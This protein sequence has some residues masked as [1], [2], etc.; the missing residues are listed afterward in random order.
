MHCNSY[1]Q[2]IVSE[3]KETYFVQ[4]NYSQTINQSHRFYATETKRLF[5]RSANFSNLG[6]SGLKS[7]IPKFTFDTGWKTNF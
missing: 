1:K 4:G 5:N 6:I 7:E 3:R 2:N